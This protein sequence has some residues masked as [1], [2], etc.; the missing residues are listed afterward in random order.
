M[1]RF[2]KFLLIT[3]GILLM[4]PVYSNVS[5]A[6]DAEM[7]TSEE[8]T[9]DTTVT[10]EEVTTEAPAPE[11][12]EE[13]KVKLEVYSAKAASVTLRWNKVK[14]ASK[15]Y[16]YRSTKKK[17]GYKKIATLK[18]SKRIYKDS[19]IKETKTYYYKVKAKLSNGKTITSNIRTKV[20]VMGDYKPGSIYGPSLSQK[21][22]NYIKNLVADVVNTC[23]TTDMDDFIK[24]YYAH[25]FVCYS[26]SYENRGWWVNS[27]NTAY[28][29]AKYGRAQCSGYARFLK[30]LCDGMG[31]GCKYV[32]ANKN[33]WNP[34]HQWNFVKIDKK[35]YLVDVQLND[36]SGYMSYLRGSD[37]LKYAAPGIYEYN[38]KGMPKLSKKDYDYSKYFEE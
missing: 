3:A 5:Y 37:F 30:A 22:L 33:A 12:V 28:G 9:Q 23:T 31:I 29:A 14:G 11:K 19:K 4:L 16:V 6:T 36:K 7:D 27:A 1:K 15:Y 26:V 38:K 25:E 2:S 32:H 21:Q 24:F 10:T 8:T 20:K 18:S 35:W 17:S 13:P 34:S